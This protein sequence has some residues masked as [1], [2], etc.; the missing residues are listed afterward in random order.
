MNKLLIL[1]LILFLWQAAKG[2]EI[3]PIAQKIID[4]ETENVFEK[5]DV[6]FNLINDDIIP[7]TIVKNPTILEFNFEAALDIIERSPEY[8]RLSIPVKNETPIEL[9][10]FK[11]N[12]FTPDFSIATSSTIEKLLL[13]NNGLH[14]WGIISND[15]TSIAAI[16]IFDNEVMGIISSS[17][18]GNF[19]LGA[20]DKDKFSRHILY[21]EKNFSA[22]GGHVCLTDDFQSSRPVKNHRQ[23]SI[24]SS[25]C[26]RLYWEVNYDLYQDRGGMS[27]VTN[28]MTGVFNQSALL[29]ANDGITVTLSQLFIWD[30][31]SPYTMIPIKDIFSQ[32]LNYRDS[33]NGDIATLI[34]I[35]GGGI[36]GNIG[37]IC[38]PNTD[39]LQCY[40]GIVPTYANVPAYSPT[41]SVITHEEGH[42]LGSYHTHAC[43]WNGNNTAIDGCAPAAGYPN[44]GSCSNAPIPANGG[45]IMSYC[46]LVST[47][48]N[49]SNG[50]GTQPKNAILDLVN[51]APCLQICTVVVATCDTPTT[52]STN[53]I[54][55]S[56]AVL[57]WN[58]AS[59][60]SSYKVQY[61]KTGNSSW[62]SITTSIDSLKLTGLSPLTNYE[63]KIQTI[64]AD[65]ISPF[66]TLKVFTTLPTASCGIPTSLNAT[67]IAQSSATLTWTA[68]A[69]ATKYTIR[70]K[71]SS[72]SSWTTISNISNTSYNLSGLSSCTSYD[73][74]VQAVCSSNSGSYSGT[75]TFSTIGCQLSYCSSKGT[76][77]SYYYINKVSIG[78]INNTSGNNGGYRNYTSLNTN[79]TRN[80]SHSITLTPS[81]G[82]YRKYWNV[83]IDYNQNGSFEDPGEKVANGNSSSSLTFN[84]TVPSG[85]LPGS[86]RMRIQMKTSSSATNSCTT[87]TYGEVEDYSVTILSVSPAQLKKGGEIN[88]GI[89]EED[90]FFKIYPDPANNYLFAE[91]ESSSCNTELI[92]FDMEGRILKKEIVMLQN[93][94]DKIEINTEELR[95]GIY[96][97]S[98]Q[99]G[100]VYQTKRFLILKDQ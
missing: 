4:A 12:F 41:I 68:V 69:G 90:P 25:K 94:I 17:K 44:E 96:F 43:V 30:S 59:Q 19:I 66:T 95:N 85:A 72:S 54:A 52:F 65:T 13:N 10:L 27:G 80:N 8:I 11:T 24:A 86:T 79:V 50:F 42:L 31:P 15:I 26:V 39:F 100:S 7:E 32:F 35:G 40:S 88:N 51:A 36:A 38:V 71:R 47:G 28:F 97:I 62:N 6:L 49:F 76:N 1:I 98:I 75:F 18:T 61:R 33:F 82:S 20:I 93:G 3:G 48:I 2:A 55:S 77:S 58:P 57:K 46:H 64:C 87:F 91:I 70:R 9:K 67:Q 45:T 92:I 37:A 5:P 53:E 74:K 73:F 34:G 29:F 14:Y 16:S 81:G 56:S 63:W 60:A 21:N 83:Y 78:S 99:T 23:N 22:P 89:S 84:F